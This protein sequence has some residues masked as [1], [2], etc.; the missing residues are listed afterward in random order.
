MTA[1]PITAPLRP[2]TG[3]RALLALAAPIFVS[4]LAV[5]GLA[6]IDTVMAGRLSADDL[7]A[8]AIGM[9]LYTSVFIGMNGL[10]QALTPIAGHHYGAGRWREI[11]RD[12]AQGHWLA[13]AMSALGVPLLAFPDPLLRLLGVGPEVAAI[14]R[15]YLMLI[16]L[17]L[18]A[19]LVARAY[20]GVNAALSRPGVAM[21]INLAM[22]AGKLPLNALFMYGAGP[23]PAMGGA[24]CALAST[25]LLWGAAA[26]YALAWRLDPFY[27]RFRLERERF[28]APDWPRIKALLQLGLPMG[29]MLLVE[30]TSFT[31]IALFVARL[32]AATL[33]GHQIIANLVSMLFMLPLALGLAAS[34][35]VSQSLG[36]GRPRQ[37]REVAWRGWRLA[38]I[39]GCAAA[40]LSWLAR[41]QIVGAY[42]TD[43][44]VA[45]I[46]L[47]L[48]ALA[49]LFHAFDA[50][51]C[52]SGMILRGYKVALAPM[53]IHGAALWGVGLGGGYALAY[54]SGFGAAYGGA[55]AFWLAAVVGLVL[56]AVALTWLANSVSRGAIVA[57]QAASA[58]RSG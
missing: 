48:M 43:A 23:L 4:Q 29:A 37:A 17:A 32:G 15:D 42:T 35:L 44:D 24:G 45:A 49:A 40:A 55:L 14:A 36:A 7:A 11:G 58:A 26:A 28:V 6:L 16:A 56:A 25:I 21:T 2:A 9:S 12:L 1:P 57:A 8:V 46:A 54:H 13:L 34:V 39:A 19:S 51:Q 22:L 18:P 41:A 20:I 31:F 3:T 47:S 27:Q 38:V 53:L 52:A 5:M 30:V 10:L 33:G 50:V